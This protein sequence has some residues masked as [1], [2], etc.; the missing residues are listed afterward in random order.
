MSE[1]Y[2]RVRLQDAFEGQRL[3]L[4]RERVTLTFYMRRAHTRVVHEVIQA[5]E[6]YI[7]AVGAH[8]LGGYFDADGEWKELDARG[9]SDVRRKLLSPRGASIELAGAPDDLTGY[10]WIYQGRLFDEP[11][12]ADDS[13]ESCVVTFSMPT[14]YLEGQGPERVR[15]LASRLAVILPFDSGHGG[16]SLQMPGWTQRN[17][18]TIRD[19]LFLHPGLDIPEP[20]L[21][22][23]LGTKLK[24]AYWLTFLGPTVLKGLGGAEGLRERLRSPG[25][26]VE[27]LHDARAVVTLG[28]W[29]EAGDLM[30]GDTLP[31]YRELARVLEPWLYFEQRCPWGNLTLDETR[32]WQRRFLD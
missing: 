23:S 29:P 2:P 25:T 11:R 31:A 9:W 5:L 20:V 4:L 16:I 7:Q 8:V 24:G 27:T 26:T 13:D 18:P 28:R 30:R 22:W 1:H 21:A 17:A 3:A 14:E 10:E 19:S 32:R 12:S 6:I 15:E